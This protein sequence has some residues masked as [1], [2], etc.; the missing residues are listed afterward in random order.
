M[1]QGGR[2]DQLRQMCKQAEEVYKGPYRPIAKALTI[3]SQVLN[4]S[5][6]ID[7]TDTAADVLG[8]VSGNVQQQTESLRTGMMMLVD[9]AGAVDLNAA[10]NDLSERS[11]AAVSGLS[12]ATC[13]ASA[14]TLEAI[15]QNISQMNR[16]LTDDPS[17]GEEPPPG[18][19]KLSG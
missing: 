1:Q 13:A 10:V 7:Y 11:T 5:L 18:S 12:G 14:D 6:D 2:K 3:T 8:G 9:W 17:E 16:L 4:C 19:E 15:Q